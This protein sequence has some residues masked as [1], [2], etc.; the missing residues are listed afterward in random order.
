MDKDKKTKVLIIQR[1]YLGDLVLTEPLIRKTKDVI[2][3]C[4]LHLLSR[5]FAREIFIYN[6]IVDAFLSFDKGEDV[7]MNTL[8]LMQDVSSKGYDIVISPHRSFR[9]SLISKAT[10]AGYKVSFSNSAGFWLYDALVEY[11]LKR[12][13]IERNLSLLKAFTG[14]EMGFTGPVIVLSDKERNEAELFIKSICDWSGQRIISIF[15]GSVWKTKRWSEDGFKALVSLLINDGFYVVVMGTKDDA[16]VCDY[17]AG[18]KISVSLAGRLN[19]RQMMILIS[20][21][22]CV[23]SN[24]SAPFHISQSLGVPVVAIFG[25]TSPEN[26]FGPFCN[27][28]ISIENKEIKCRPCGLHGAVSCPLKH[29]LCMRSIGVMSVY[30]TVRRLIEG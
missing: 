3:D 6:D 27:N 13:E 1:G 22:S 20:L 14:V 15:P 24:D 23:V 21:S 8:K 11:E 17:V 4:E 7:L 29:H 9:T 16:D 30:K 2:K 19:L 25:P 28:A 26:G 5:R 12:H 10:G 18:D